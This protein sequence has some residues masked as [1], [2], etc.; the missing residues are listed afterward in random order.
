MVVFLDAVKVKSR[1]F[2][3][4]SCLLFSVLSSVNIYRVTFTNYSNGV[5]LAKYTIHGE[6]TAI[7]K[8]SIQRS[9]F[10]QVLL[11]SISGMWIM[12]Q[13]KKM[14]FMIFVTT[15]IYRNSGTASRKI[16]SRSF[17]NS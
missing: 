5:K 12:L 9:I 4:F 3:I 11:F 7:W 13:D 1:A 15:N 2:V 10:I 16:F 14:E 6:E 8:R 17:S